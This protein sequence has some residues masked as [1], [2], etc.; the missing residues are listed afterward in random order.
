MLDNAIYL[1]N[2]TES[3]GGSAAHRQL[4]CDPTPDNDAVPTA[5]LAECLAAKIFGAV[6]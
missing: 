4:F 2:P 3:L 1:S 5:A 6:V